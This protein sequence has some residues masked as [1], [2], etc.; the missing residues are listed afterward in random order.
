MINS[1]NF[2]LSKPK[3]DPNPLKKATNRSAKW[4]QQKDESDSV[5]LASF[6]AEF[7]HEGVELYEWSQFL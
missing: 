1:G 6:D 2:V 3:K 4:R 5:K 7:D